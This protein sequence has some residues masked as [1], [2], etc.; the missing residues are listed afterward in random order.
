MAEQRAAVKRIVRLGLYAVLA[1]IPFE[2]PNRVTLPVEVP[3]LAGALFLATALLQPRRCFGRVPTAVWWFLAYLCVCALAT[4]VNFLN[5]AG[6]VL[7]EFLLI[8]QGVLVFWAASNV[9]DD[10]AVTATALV[11]FAAACLLRSVLPM[12]GIGRTATVVWTGGERLTA[13]GQNENNAAMFLAGGLLTLLGVGFARARAVVRPRLLVLPACALIAY[14]AIE[15]GSRGGLL[16]LLAGLATFVLAAGQSAWQRVRNVALAILGLAAL[17]GLAYETPVMRNRVRESAEE[18]N[19]AG[20]EELYPLLGQMFA[21]KPL[22][23]WGPLNNQYELSIREGNRRLIRR[24]AHNLVLEALTST[25]LLGAVPFCFAIWLCLRAAWRA[26]ASPEGILPLVLVVSVLTADMSGN[27]VASKLLW[28][29]FAYAVASARRRPRDARLCN[30]TAT[31]TPGPGPARD[32]QHTL[33]RQL[34]AAPSAVRVL[35]GEQACPSSIP[36]G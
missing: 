15:T 9:L 6:E 10:E 8:L 14:A 21:E 5:D 17:L 35:Q 27:W 26:R 18:G 11:T 13:F 28:F 31:T 36:P 7:H 30:G 19:M 23:G 16:A 2:L 4:S 29:N 3:T 1:S 33:G 32:T 34:N 24:D 25:G 20:R 22:I 12:V